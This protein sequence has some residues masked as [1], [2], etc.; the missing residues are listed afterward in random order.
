MGDNRET[1]SLRPA[2]VTAGSTNAFNGSDVYN[3]YKFRVD[4]VTALGSYELNPDTAYDIRIRYRACTVY[5]GPYTVLDEDGNPVTN[6]QPFNCKYVNACDP[7]FCQDPELDEVVGLGGG[8]TVLHIPAG[9]SLADVP[10][11]QRHKTLLLDNPRDSFC[12]SE[13]TQGWGYAITPEFE[14]TWDTGDAE[15][16]QDEF[17]GRQSFTGTTARRNYPAVPICN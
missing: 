16:E 9:G 6:G 11:A 5:S 13:Y 15:F 10:L 3:P 7:A 2:M 14:F 17:T 8:D 4:V 1:S 12:F